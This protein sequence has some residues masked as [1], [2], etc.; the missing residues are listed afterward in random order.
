[1][2]LKK[3]ICRIIFIFLIKFSLEF[4]IISEIRY[5]LITNKMSTI[6]SSDMLNRKYDINNNYVIYIGRKTCP[7]Y[8]KMI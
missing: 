1:M 8:V 3:I 2:E 4:N 7:D 6:N 5:K